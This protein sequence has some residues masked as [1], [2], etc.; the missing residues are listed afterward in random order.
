MNPAALKKLVVGFVLAVP[1]LV[2]IDVVQYMSV[3]GVV[4][5]HRRVAS[6]HLIIREAEGIASA[7]DQAHTALSGYLATRKAEPLTLYQTASAQAQASLQRLVLLTRLDAAQQGR[8]QKLEPAVKKRLELFQQ[9]LECETQQGLNPA[10]Q[11][12]LSPQA[13]KEMESIRAVL[14]DMAKHELDRL[15]ALSATAQAS[16]G[17]TNL[18]TPIAAVL[19]VWMVLVAALLLYRDA[20]RRSWAG[21]ERR[22]HTRL[23]ETLPLGVC[24]VDEHGL[25]FFTNPAQDSLFGYE[26]GG[27]VGRHIS[28]LHNAP[29]GE[30]NDPFNQAMQ[31][32]SQ[33]GEWRGEFRGRKRNGTSFDCLS[34]A[35]T[36]DLAGKPYRVLLLASQGP[37]SPA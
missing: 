15:P 6:A 12:E 11:E 30:G 32:L 3:Q 7:L 2:V 20:T 17:R 13:E 9:A 8:V 33:R 10:K 27:L 34:Q 5:S 35:V 26:P 37:L 18:V 29:R 14:A 23:V 1:V 4:N 25:I 21:I 36:M 19:G 24:L 16:I 22:L 31:D 28:A